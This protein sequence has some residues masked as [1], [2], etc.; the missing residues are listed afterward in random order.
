M[1]NFIKRFRLKEV[2]S[3]KVKQII[4]FHLWYKQYDNLRYN[5][6]KLSVYENKTEIVVKLETYRPGLWIGKGGRDIDEL[7]KVLTEK[8]G[9]EV[10]IELSECKLWHN[11]Y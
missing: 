3:K 11:I 6:T 7:K 5:V 9:K 8:L 1:F 10:R 2:D 4:S